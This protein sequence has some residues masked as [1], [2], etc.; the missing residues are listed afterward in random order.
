MVIVLVSSCGL[1]VNRSLFFTLLVLSWWMIGY[2]PS[3]QICP[4]VSSSALQSLHMV[5]HESFTA[6]NFHWFQIASYFTAWNVPWLGAFSVHFYYKTHFHY[7]K[8][9]LIV[10]HCENSYHSMQPKSSWSIVCCWC[11]FPYGC[12]WPRASWSGLWTGCLSSGLHIRSRWLRYA[13]LYMFLP[14]D[15]FTP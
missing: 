11:V 4:C 2:S 3:P 5:V 15:T 1:F 7:M 6:W 13:T 8:F 14:S 12:L 9:S 10:S